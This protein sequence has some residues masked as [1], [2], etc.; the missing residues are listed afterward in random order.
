[1]RWKTGGGMTTRLTDTSA[2]FGKH[3]TI[4]EF[5]ATTRFRSERLAEIEVVVTDENGNTVEVLEKSD[6]SEDCDFDGGSYGLS[7]ERYPRKS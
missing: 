6:V 4:D 5:V 2:V 7:L 3:S 1:M